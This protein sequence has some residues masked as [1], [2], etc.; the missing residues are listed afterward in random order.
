MKNKWFRLLSL[1]I[2]FSGLSFAA[3]AQIFVRIR[4]SAP[5]KVRPPQPS[6][7]HIWIGNDWVPEGNSYRYSGGHWEAPPH[8]NDR[9]NHGHWKNHGRKGHQWIRGGW[10]KK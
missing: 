5:A 3:Q 2:I 9:W 7:L 8:E 1:V 4:P 6:H 10:R